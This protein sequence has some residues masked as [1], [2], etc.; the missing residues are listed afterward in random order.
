MPSPEVPSELIN[1]IECYIDKKTVMQTSQF[2][3]LLFQIADISKTPIDALLR[4]PID[5]IGKIMSFQ[6]YKNKTT[7]YAKHNVNNFF[8]TQK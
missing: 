4:L 5:D 3:Y 1:A 8:K 6:S 2:D 7:A